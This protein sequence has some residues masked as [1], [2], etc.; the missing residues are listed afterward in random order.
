VG[1][2]A[3]TLTTSLDKGWLVAMDAK[4]VGHE[5]AW[6]RAAQ[7]E[8]KATRVPSVLQETFPGYNWCP[9][10]RNPETRFAEVPSSAGNGS[11]GRTSR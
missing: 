10:G 5:A 1:K 8:A 4:N 9:V 7:P 6:F 3:H 2:S 11:I